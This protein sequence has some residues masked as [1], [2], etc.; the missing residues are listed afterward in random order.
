MRLPKTGVRRNTRPSTWWEGPPSRWPIKLAL[1]L[2]M[3]AL[4]L[5]LCS[6]LISCASPCQP[7]V[8]PSRTLDRTWADSGIGISCKWRW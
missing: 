4:V 3:L 5:T 2:A 6:L 1:W 8:E 7:S